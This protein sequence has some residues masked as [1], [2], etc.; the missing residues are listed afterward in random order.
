MRVLHVV[1]GLASRTGGVATSTVQG[2][3]A[4]EAH[5]VATTVLTTDLAEA[6]SARRHRRV[7][8]EELPRGADGLDIR[9]FRARPPYRLAF[10]PELHRAVGSTVGSFDVVHIHSLFLFPQWSAFHHARAAGIPFV[11]SPRGSLDPYLR[12]RGRIRK[13]IVS[14]LWQRRMLEHAAAL[15]PTT[16]AEAALFADIAPRVPRVVVPNPIEWAIYQSLP[17]GEPFR[18]RYLAGHSGPVVLNLGRLSHK[19]GLDILIRAFARVHAE[20]PDSRLVIAG[21]DDEGLQPRLAVL[22]AREGVGTATVFTGMLTGQDRLAAL[23]AADVWAL[24]SHTENFGVAVVEALAAGIPTVIS[25]AVNIAQEAARAEAVLVSDLESERF[26]TAILAL[27]RDRDRAAALGERGRSFARRY[28]RFAVGR[29]LTSA[30]ELAVRMCPRMPERRI[31][32][33]GR[34][35][36]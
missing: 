21:P 30:Y 1:P 31:A 3:L 17:D 29:Q 32:T 26:A 36:W 11:V 4:V 9:I 33:V 7:T 24:S 16:D 15:I 8:S 35:I 10:S 13:A 19:K 14:T 22:A 34:F 23:A 5:G 2:C 6:A 25:P 20:D 12:R 28:D 27:L 18:R